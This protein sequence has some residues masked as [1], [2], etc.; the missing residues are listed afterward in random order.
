[1]PRAYPR[2]NDATFAGV[3]RAN[4]SAAS[5]DRSPPPSCPTPSSPHAYTS[6]S[7]VNTTVCSLPA[8]TLDALIGRPRTRVGGVHPPAFAP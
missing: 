6:P 4:A 5:E 2:G 8:A 1:M 3:G 7:R